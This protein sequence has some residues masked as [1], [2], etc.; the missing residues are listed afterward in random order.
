MRRRTA[1]VLLLLLL[2]APLLV[3]GLGWGWLMHYARTPGPLAEETSYVLRYGTPSAAIGQQLEAQGII[4]H[5]EAF[6]L[7]VRYASL[8]AHVQAGEYAISPHITPAQLIA[9]LQSGKVMQRK[10]MVPEG[11]TSV[12]IRRVLQE[13]EA[14]EGEVPEIAEGSLLPDT[15]FYMRGD[16]RAE[17]VAQ[18]REAQQ[19]LLEALWP[20]RSPE[21]VVRSPEEA[22]ILASVVEKETGVEAERTRVAAVFSNRLRLGMPLQADPT[23]SYGLTGG[24]KLDRLL[25]R[26]DLQT[27]NP[28]NSYLNR[29]LPPTPI[30]HPGRASIAAVLHPADSK[31]LYFVATGSGG[32]WFAETLEEHNRNVARYRRTLRP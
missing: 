29:G 25:S 30:C 16:S 32:H 27:P 26:V 11:L 28:Y 14:L 23:V 13:A 1:L 9:L 21:A 17:L 8:Q 18:M 2:G 6:Y 10:V 7:L 15:Y 5:A 24:E 19:A 31:D 12:Q 3:A 20:E 22:L 4:E